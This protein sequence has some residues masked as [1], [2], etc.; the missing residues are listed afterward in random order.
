MS[1][2]DQITKM[3]RTIYLF[4]IHLKLETIQVS[5]QVLFFLYLLR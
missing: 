4:L 5:I 3:I 1:M 2:I